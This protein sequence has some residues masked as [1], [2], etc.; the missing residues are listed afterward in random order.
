MKTSLM[1]CV[2]IVG[3]I[4][5]GCSSSVEEQ[6]HEFKVNQQKEKQEEAEKTV[7][8][9]PDWFLEEEPSAT[10]L[11]SGKG[12]IRRGSPVSALQDAKTLAL[13]DLAQKLKNNVSGISKLYQNN[14]DVKN[15]S[16]SQ[17]AIEAIVKQTDV[18]GYVI[19]KKEL[20]AENGSYRAFIWLVWDVENAVNQYQQNLQNSKGA[21]QSANELFEEL[22]NKSSN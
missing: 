5:S 21:K 22:N 10:T 2:V 9:I 16:S 14:L 19:H 20:I 6:V 3:F 7:D 8:N 18:T 12:T 13:Y 17:L 15:S 1:L 4:S 11:L